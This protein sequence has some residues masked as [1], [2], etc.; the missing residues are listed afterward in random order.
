MSGKRR[1]EKDRVVAESVCARS[2]LAIVPRHS[3]S[4]SRS[5]V[6]FCASAKEQTNRASRFGPGVLQLLQQLANTVLIRGPRA[7]IAGGADSRPS[8]SASIS[9]PESSANTRNA[10]FGNTRLLSV[11][12]FLQ[13][14]SRNSSAWRIWELMPNLRN[15]GPRLQK[16]RD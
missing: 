8:P 10:P 15:P 13:T 9:R 14:W 1:K 5:S 12:R 16:T 2:S 11:A 4:D 6:P 3:P 7:G